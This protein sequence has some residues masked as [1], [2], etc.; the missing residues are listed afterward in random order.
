MCLSRINVDMSSS[1]YQ[2][3]K[4]RNLKGAER[5]GNAALCRFFPQ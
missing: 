5:Y 2:E 3:A 4:T 1:R